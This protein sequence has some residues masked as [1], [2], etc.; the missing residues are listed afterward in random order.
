MP[1]HFIAFA[2]SHVIANASSVLLDML[3]Q[4]GVGGAFI[5][6]FGLVMRLTI[7]WMHKLYDK[8]RIADEK[9]VSATMNVLTS[10]IELISE[11]SKSLESTAS[12]H[13]TTTLEQRELL[14]DIESLRKSL[15]EEIR[16]VLETARK[17]RVARFN[18]NTNS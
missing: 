10:Q 18:E 12:A 17:E 5:V 16:D 15:R 1:T 9:A 11:I 2:D 3:P 4:L 13:L 6:G 8:Q 14:H 7:E